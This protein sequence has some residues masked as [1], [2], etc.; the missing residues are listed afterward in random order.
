MTNIQINFTNKTIELSNKFAK[1][2]SQYGTEEYAQLM[3][4]R[5]D[6]PTFEIKV[7]KSVSK[8]NSNLKGLTLKYMEEY[9]S[10]KE[11]NEEL[12]KEFNTLRGNTEEDF[13]GR[14]TYGEIKKWFLAKCPEVKTKAEEIK[15]IMEK[16]AA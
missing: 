14:A 10:K 6:F 8:N 13:A 16:L 7:L 15:K 9:I 3:S 4:A 12:M 11:D 2:A 1:A 5:N